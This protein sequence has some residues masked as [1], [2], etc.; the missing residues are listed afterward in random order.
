MRQKTLSKMTD[1]E[2]NEMLPYAF[3]EIPLSIYETDNNFSVYSMMP[4]ARLKR[5]MLDIPQELRSMQYEDIRDL[6]KP[7]ATLNQL[8]MR[9]WYEYDKVACGD[10]SKIYLARMHKGICS[11]SVLKSIVKDP[12]KFAYI[13][14]PINSYQIAVQDLLETSM[15]KIR[16]ALDEVDIVTTKDLNTVLKVY[17]AFDK[18]IHG[19]YKKN[20]AIEANE[21]VKDNF[22]SSK[23]LLDFIEGDDND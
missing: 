7:N 17:E 15:Y 12:E 18:R 13:L 2:K 5:Q 22:G 20:I 11:E 4:N 3:E 1:E 9:F 14:T 10:E 8:R 6:V 23:E 21:N 19:D 16:K